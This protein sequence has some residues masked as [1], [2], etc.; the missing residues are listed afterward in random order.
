MAKSSLK[1]LKPCQPSRSRGF[2]ISAPMTSITF[3]S[4]TFGVDP[5]RLVERE[6]NRQINEQKRA[7]KRPMPTDQDGWSE[8]R[9]AAEA[10]FSIP[11]A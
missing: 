11:E 6:Q 5:M 4:R 3:K 1:I 8:A 9:K 7:E 2:F 10:L